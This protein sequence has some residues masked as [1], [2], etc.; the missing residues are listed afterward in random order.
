MLLLT[1][2]TIKGL[3]IYAYHGLFEQE[4]SLGQKFVFDVEAEL[5]AGGSH[6]DD[7]LRASV[8][9]DTV[10]DETVRL[11]QAETLQTLEALGE[12]IVRG[13]LER[14]EPMRSVCVTVA[15]L[16]PPIPHPLAHVGVKIA[17]SRNDVEHAMQA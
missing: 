15:K 10:V 13:L 9:Y 1:S 8:R 2:I 17:L 12:K 7:S 4:R 14:F 5:R 6:Q 16:S 3:E 11:V